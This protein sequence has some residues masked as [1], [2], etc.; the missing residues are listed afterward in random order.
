MRYIYG[1]R[2]CIRCRPREGFIKQVEDISNRYYGI[3]MYSRQLTDKERQ[4]Y[5]LDYLGKIN[6]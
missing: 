2:L 4:E 6:D 1:M 3:L 5:N